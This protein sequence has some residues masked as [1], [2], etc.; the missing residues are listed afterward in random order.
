MS[1]VIKESKRITVL[2][3]SDTCKKEK[4]TRDKINME[5]AAEILVSRQKKQEE[6][7]A[8]HYSLEATHKHFMIALLYFILC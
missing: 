4:C 3:D 8:I 6:T 7:S 5:N 2:G 1:V